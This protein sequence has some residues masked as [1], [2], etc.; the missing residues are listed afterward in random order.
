MDVDYIAMGKR[1]RSYR[2][3]QNLTQAELGELAKV[4]PSNIS[5][6]ERGATK[7]SFPTLVKIAN[8]LGVS[9]DDIVTDS[10]A[11]NA[12]VSIK[13]FEIL[14]SDCTDEELKSMLEIAKTTK[15]VLRKN[16]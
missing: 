7:L 12:H 2:K 9:L 16:R 1:I 3:T 14:F 4:E 6:I 15:D 13:D 10:I 8:A 5:H 11:K